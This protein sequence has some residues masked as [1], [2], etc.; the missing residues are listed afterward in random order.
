MHEEKMSFLELPGNSECS[1]MIHRL[2]VWMSMFLGVKS[3]PLRIVIVTS[4]RRPPVERCLSR[5]SKRKRK[6][7]HALH[8]VR[9]LHH[10]NNLVQN[11]CS[12]E[13]HFEFS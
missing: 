3:A 12:T 6:T 2:A 8:P 1:Y 10:K 13:F 9:H 7:F 11:L 4:A 5:L